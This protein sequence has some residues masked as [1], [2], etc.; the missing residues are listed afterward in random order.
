MAFEVGGEV[1]DACV[2]DDGG[3]GGGGGGGDGGPAG[4]LVVLLVVEH[5]QVEG[6]EQLLLDPV[7]QRGQHVPQQG[8]YVQQGGVSALLGGLLGQGGE[9][10]VEG[11]AFGFQVGEGAQV[12]FAHGLDRRG[13][14]VLCGE[15]LD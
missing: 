11:V 4:D 13:V 2:G 3:Q 8:Q 10:A 7:R 9:F 6:V 1:A 14:G 5:A 12:P 15:G